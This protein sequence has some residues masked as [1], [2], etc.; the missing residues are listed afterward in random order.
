MNGS[1]CRGEV[2]CRSEY[3]GRGA[4]LVTTVRTG[5]KY[6]FYKSRECIL[7]VPGKVFAQTVAI[8]P[9]VGENLP[10]F[11]SE[12]LRIGQ[13]SF[14][15]VDFHPPG[16]EKTDYGGLLGQFPARSVQ[17]SRH[18]DLD[19]WFSPVLWIERGDMGVR[20]AFEREY[21]ARLGAYYSLLNTNLMFGG[22]G[23]D[24]HEAF[25][26]YM[27]EHDPARGILK[28]YF[29]AEFAND[30]LRL[31]LFGQKSVCGVH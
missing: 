19:T 7:T 25:N 18:Y 20:R 23:P 16:T 1:H 21:L 13:N 2:K 27:A 26:G 6:G 15:A 29:G 9:S 5:E 4:S 8:Y 31:V 10:I 12:Y 17:S 30:Y 24:N 3:R 14:G 11:A 28:A 22:A